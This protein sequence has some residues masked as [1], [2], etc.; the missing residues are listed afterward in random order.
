MSWLRANARR[1]KERCAC[2]FLSALSLFSI[3]GSPFALIAFPD[4]TLIFVVDYFPA[5]QCR[6]QWEL[7]PLKFLVRTD[8]VRRGCRQC[9]NVMMS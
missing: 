6:L 5:R 9:L 7:D 1:R 2:H 8:G 3:T 4:S